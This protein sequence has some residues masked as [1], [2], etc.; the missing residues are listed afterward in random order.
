ML[1]SVLSASLLG[2]VGRPVTVEVHQSS[3][4]PSFTV[5][6]LPDTACREARDRVRAAV[7]STGCEWPPRRITVNLAPSGVRKIGSS[8]DLAMAVGVLIADEKV[9][10]EAVQGLAF[11]GELGLDGSVR[12]VHGALPLVDALGGRVAVVAPGN[13]A[14]ARLVGRHEVR[15]VNTLEELCE[16]LRCEAPW[17]DVVTPVEPDVQVPSS[18]LADVRGHRHARFA[19]EVAAAGDHHLLLIGPPGAG[20]TMLAAR[21]PGLLGE[22]AHDEAL[23]ATKIHSAAGECLPKGTLVRQPP[24]RAPHHSAS[25]VSVIGGGHATMRPGEISLAHRGVLFLDEMGEFP[26]AVLDSLRQPL[27]EGVVRVSRAQFSV[28]YPA[29][30]LLVGAM[31]P[32]PC[33]FF[34][35]IRCTCTAAGI[36]R[37]GRRLSGPLLDRFDLRVAVAPPETSTL[38]AAGGGEGSASVASRVA[39]ARAR[40]RRRGVTANSR[41][42]YA[43]LERLT[44]LEPRAQSLLERAVSEQRLS[45]RGLRRVRAVA[46][47]IDDLQGGSGTLSPAT[48][49]QALALRADL[50][51]R[52]VPVMR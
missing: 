11:V 29:R 19:L 36:L 7:M 51:P 34:G 13:V 35:G 14:E 30:F 6:G 45:P 48:V 15:A 41:L 49:A 9:P 16:A 20:K 46:L 10:A 12:P 2:V 44:K 27:E 22:L 38:F 43:D 26:A 33:G 32:C 5:V 42:S 37:Y 23:E 25:L 28:E 18:D 40:A 1:A 17:P 8:L 24:F 39:A 3:G 50:W 47:T 21:L 52:A 4:L 31:N